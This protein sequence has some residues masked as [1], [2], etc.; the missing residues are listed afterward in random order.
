VPPGLPADLDA[1]AREAY[2][3][4]L[5][6]RIMT[7]I[8]LDGRVFCSNAI[9]EGRFTLRVCIVNFRTEADEM[10]LV[11]DVAAELGTQLD[12]EMR[13]SLAERSA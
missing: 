6:R 2:L 12:R 7:G 5:N 4:A 8:Q 3:S 13:P 11:L 1:D 10:D 9:L